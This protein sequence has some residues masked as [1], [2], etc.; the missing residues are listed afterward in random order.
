[1]RLGRF[2]WR[3]ETTMP[4]FERGKRQRTDEIYKAARGVGLENHS[5][6][7]G[8]GCRHRSTLSLVPAPAVPVPHQ[9]DDLAYRLQCGPHHA[10][11]KDDTDTA[12]V[13]ICGADVDDVPFGVTEL[14]W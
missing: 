7:R 8:H 3:L 14:E 9:R 10:S 1:M 4:R 5:K 12:L 6:P 11:F 2:S 13:T